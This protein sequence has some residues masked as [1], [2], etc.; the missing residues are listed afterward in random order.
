MRFEVEYDFQL[1]RYFLDSFEPQI[2]EMQRVWLAG[3]QEDAEQIEDPEDLAEFWQYISE[4]DNDRAEFKGILMNSFF[5]GSFALFEHHLN[6][7]CDFAG[8]RRNI[9]FT[10]RDLRGGTLE[11]PKKYLKKVE[12]IF[13]DDST[14]WERITFYNQVRNKIMHERGS[15]SSEDGIYERAKECEIVTDARLSGEFLELTPE[16]CKSALDDFQQF[17]VEANQVNM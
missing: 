11:K 7:I 14:E 9:P 3:V 12:G 5:A 17:L 2:D 13:P 8:R 4:T 6:E 16:F 15:I 1:Y 10:A